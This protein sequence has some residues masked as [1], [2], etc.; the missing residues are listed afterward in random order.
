MRRVQSARAERVIDSF[1]KVTGSS[2]SGG[3]TLA[4]ARSK[5]DARRQDA[6]IIDLVQLP[7]GTRP[8]P[9]AYLDYDEVQTRRQMDCDYYQSCLSFAAR[10]RWKSFHCRQCPQHPERADELPP[11]V[12]ESAVEAAII[13]FR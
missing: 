13:E 6:D 5:T 2:K 11:E 3:S 8:T 10:V 12:E 1:A 7:R 4:V 9:I